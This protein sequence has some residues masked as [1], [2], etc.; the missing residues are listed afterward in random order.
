MPFIKISDIVITDRARKELGSDFEDLKESIRVRGLLHPICVSKE[1]NELVA[2]FRRL[3]CHIQL[4]LSEIEVR[5]KEELS[6]IEKKLIELEEN[7]HL[8]LS[9][10]EKAELRSQIHILQQE[11][12]GK[13]TRGHESDGR[14]LE[15]TAQDLKVSI[16]TLSQDMR[17]AKALE[18]LPELRKITSRRQALKAIDQLEEVALLT[19]LANLD[20]ESDQSE[21]PTNKPYVLIN[22]DAAEEMPAR[23]DDEVVDM[24]IFDPPWGIDSQIIASGRGPRGE[25]MSYKDDTTTTA[26]SIALDLLP[27]LYRVMKPDAHMYMFIGI[28]F[29]E[30]YYDFLTNFED[31]PTRIQTWKY[32]MPILSKQLDA[33]YDQVVE[34]NKSRPWSFH[35]EMVP[36]VWIKEGGGFTDFDYKFMP[37]YESILFCSKGQKKRLNDVT[38]NVFE[39]KRPVTTERIH[40]QEKPVDL[41]QKFIK[42][43]TQPNEIV[44]DPCAGSFTTAVAATLSGRRSICIEKDPIVYARGVQRLSGLTSTTENEGDENG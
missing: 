42:I 11:V 23:I 8:E 30:L 1:D 19:A 33:L 26:L 12:Y 2:G 18:E 16:A 3:Q 21:N 32:F 36:L 35:V 39:F 10:D 5:Y 17:L 31:F 4:G 25:K 38:S 37:Q 28:Q 6:P 24:V 29:R 40:T 41:I 7:I 43:S 13:A 34:I 44:L 20:A 9:W 22:G 14:K 15:D 27:E